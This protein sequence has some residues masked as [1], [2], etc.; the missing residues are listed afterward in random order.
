ME[1]GV[2]MAKS[3]ETIGY[4]PL[5][6]VQNGLKSMELNVEKDV[7][8]AKIDSKPWA[9]VHWKSIKTKYGKGCENG[10]NRQSNGDFVCIVYI[11]FINHTKEIV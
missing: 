9:I 4:S 7:K 6:M 11:V 3:I 10:N 8:M 1:K 5:K 2:K